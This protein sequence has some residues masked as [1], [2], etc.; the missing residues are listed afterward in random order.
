MAAIQLNYILHGDISEAGTISTC[1]VQEPVTV[2]TIKELFPYDGIFHFRIKRPIHENNADHGGIGTDYRWMD[3]LPAS[4]QNIQ[5]INNLIEIQALV[6]CLPSNEMDNETDGQ[7]S[8]TVILQE[9]N[10]IYNEIG[11]NVN[12]RP[13]R[14]ALEVENILVDDENSPSPEDDQSSF[15]NTA[16]NLAQG[17]QNITLSSV[18]KNAIN[19]WSTVKSTAT[20]FGMQLNTPI[21]N[22]NKIHNHFTTSYDDSIQRHVVVLQELW[23]ALF[24]GE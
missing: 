4:N 3:I 16:L 7:R 19:I 21:D 9:M 10:D 18:T 11:L 12:N 13:D 14:Q 23:H 5:P 1:L 17:L 2:T 22:L 24:P 8:T 15:T 6:L 20:Q